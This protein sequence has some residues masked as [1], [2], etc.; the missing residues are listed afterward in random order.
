[1]G[2]TA[3]TQYH[4]L[5]KSNI[6]SS[7]TEEFPC[8]QLFL[9][10]M[11]LLAGNFKLSTQLKQ[12][13]FWMAGFFILF[14]KDGRQAH[15]TSCFPLCIQHIL[16]W[17]FQIIPFYCHH[18]M[19]IISLGLFLFYLQYTQNGKVTVNATLC[20]VCEFTLT[21]HKAKMIVLGLV[22]HILGSHFLK[23]LNWNSNTLQS[24]FN[25]H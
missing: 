14:S 15:Y 18:F 23:N 8:I 12:N 20:I 1:M 13:T 25:S 9:V 4:G 2:I 16:S 6:F 21:A 10:I 17:S 19:C 11:H 24:S 3:P 5:I 7:N 22:D